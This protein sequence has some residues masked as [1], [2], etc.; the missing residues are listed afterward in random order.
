LNANLKCL[1]GLGKEA[2]SFVTPLIGLWGK[3]A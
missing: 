3:P 2:R 1:G